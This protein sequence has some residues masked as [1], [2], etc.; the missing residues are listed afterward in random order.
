M[1]K[2]R[3]PARMT[4]T[5]RL[6]AARPFCCFCGGK[7][8]A[9]TLDH[10]PPIILFP[11]R[12][13]P[14]GMEFPACLP[15]NKSTSADEPVVALIA[16]LSGSTRIGL[17]QPDKHFLNAVKAVDRCHPS[18]CD[19]ILG[20]RQSLSVRGIHQSVGT[21]RLDHPQIALSCCRVAAKLG[22]AVYC[23]SNGRPAQQ[24]T[25][26]STFWTHNQ[27]KGAKSISDLLEKFPTSHALG[28]GTRVDS[29]AAFFYR[30][31]YENGTLHMLAILHETIALVC[32]LRDPGAKLSR[33]KWQHT[34]EL[35]DGD[36]LVLLS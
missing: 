11:D 17:S 36:G 33:H 16:R 30:H 6:L 9:T 20:P 26:I 21:F 8:S 22:V 24:G 31:H 15:C 5:A 23:E 34:W 19:S 25:I 14:K 28:Q 3:N 27:R 13:R 2:V 35:R 32:Q 29:S 10:Q 12:N 18:L 7:T 4:A 1:A